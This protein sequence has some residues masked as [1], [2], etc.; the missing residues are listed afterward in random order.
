MTSSPITT[1]RDSFQVY[2]F[3]NPVRSQN[4]RR[5]ELHRTTNL[6]FNCLQHLGNN[7]RVVHNLYRIITISCLGC[8]GVLHLVIALFICVYDSR[9]KHT[10][11]QIVRLCGH[12]ATRRNSKRAALMVTEDGQ[13]EVLVNTK[14]ASSLHAAALQKV[15]RIPAPPLKRFVSRASLQKQQNTCCGWKRTMDDCDSNIIRAP[16][17]CAD[18]PPVSKL[19]ESIQQEKHELQET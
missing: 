8:F 13:T 11:R 2:S 4:I 3:C 18:P 9:R 19:S 5:Q 14:V 17:E 15:V 6:F 1:T 7:I 16:P 10:Y 12:R